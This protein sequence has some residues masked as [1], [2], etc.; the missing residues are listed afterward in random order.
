MIFG[1][2][3]HELNKL[4]TRAAERKRLKEKMWSACF[5][6]KGENT[7]VSTF[8]VSSSLG[9]PWKGASMMYVLF[10]PLKGPGLEPFF[11]EAGYD[12]LQI[13]LQ[14]PIQNPACSRTGGKS[15]HQAAAQP[16]GCCPGGCCPHQPIL[17]TLLPRIQSRGSCK[18]GVWWFARN[19]I[20]HK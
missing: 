6:V 2:H 16:G 17:Q 9:V 11:G 10:F 14:N 18:P 13:F 15:S 19:C 1:V 12:V 4:C 8:L 7:M 20:I 5:K 3:C